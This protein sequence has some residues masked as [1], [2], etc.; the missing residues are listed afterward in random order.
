MSLER[1]RQPLV[2]AAALFTLAGGYLHLQEW[3]DGYRNVP[4]DAPGAYVVR[5][6]FPVSAGTALALAVA[7]VAT[8]WVGR[9]LSPYVMGAAAVF[10]AVSLGI[11]I[12]TRTGS[13]LG[14]TEPVW[15]PGA[16]QIRAVEV[17]ALLALAA[18][19]LITTAAR[20]TYPR[21]LPVRSPATG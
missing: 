16:D 19:A 20:R 18:T 1:H 15:T 13:V 10:N 4:A 2:L 3:L 5:I 7:L 9:R 12:A 6:G 8:L 21:P 17:G 11:L 14:W